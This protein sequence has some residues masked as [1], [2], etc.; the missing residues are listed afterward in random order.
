MG[1]PKNRITC[2]DVCSA[3]GLTCHEETDWSVGTSGM[4]QTFSA[5]PS[6]MRLIL[7]DCDEVPLAS[8]NRNGV[9]EPL[10]AYQCGCVPE[11]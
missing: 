9:V 7:G 6:E 5:V 4:L 11:P 10:V 3:E 1:D 8:V 2:N